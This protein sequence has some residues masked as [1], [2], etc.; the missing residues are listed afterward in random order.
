MK[1][2]PRALSGTNGVFALMRNAV[3]AN[4]LAAAVDCGVFSQLSDWRTA[5]D[6]AS[7]LR[8]HPESTKRF[9][10]LLEFCAVVCR[11]ADAYRNAAGTQELLGDGACADI[12]PLVREMAE[13]VLLPMQDLR[14]ILREGPGTPP[15][16]AA[17]AERGASDE[18]TGGVEGSACWAFR[19]VAGQV[20]A[21]LAALPGAETFRRMLDLGGGHGVFSLYAA[22]ALPALDVDVYDL[23]ASLRSAAGYIAEWGFADRVR[24]VP[25]DY[26]RD[27]LPGGY[28]V[29]LASCTLNFTLP[30][31]STALVMD[32]LHAA[33]VPGGYCISLHDAP[34]AFA[35]ETRSCLSD[36]RDIAA[37]P[38]EC[39]A[40][41]LVYGRPMA[42]PDGLIAETMLQSGF[43][44]VHSRELRTSGGT[45]RLDIARKKPA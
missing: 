24:T 37:Y 41:G 2:L 26:V 14:R 4:A 44:C 31:A 45:F 29:A 38:L 32:K 3:A 23:P 19:G 33:L 5:Q 21:I 16:P 15:P 35:G 18:G 27:R 8:L 6:V 40:I 7:R 9:L 17:P 12:A 30:D 11:N 36:G 22:E 34:P 42:M 10:D 13:G 25:G 39:M 1:K 28:D 20:A 43:A